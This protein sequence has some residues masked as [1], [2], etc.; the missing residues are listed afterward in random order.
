MTAS[1]RIDDES[2]DRLKQLAE[3]EDRPMTRIVRA[4]IDAYDQQKLAKATSTVSHGAGTGGKPAKAP[5]PS[6]SQAE[7]DAAEKTDCTHPKETL[8]KLAWGTLC[9]KCGTVVK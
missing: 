7:I 2:F 4:A 5:V 6:L 3:D 8:R 9:G 1:V